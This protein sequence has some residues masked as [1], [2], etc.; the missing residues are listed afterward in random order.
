VGFRPFVYRLAGELDLNGWVLNSSAGL[1]VE[2]EG[3]EAALGQFLTRLDREKPAAAVVLTREVSW[4]APAG[5]TRFEILASDA[6]AEKTAAV[7]PD[8]ATCGD[9][10][11]ELLDPADRRY[12]YPFTNCT[13]C[14]PRYT[15][16][17]DIPYDR[18]RTTMRGFQMCEA[19]RRE[20]GSMTPRYG[21]CFATLGAMPGAPD[22]RT[23]TMGAAGDAIAAASASEIAQ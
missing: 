10:L 7:L 15:I 20:Y 17:L 23:S 19:C 6:G 3:P 21:E 14:G 4:L 1:V 9:C 22:G 12:L 13:N 2:V 18:P 16:I 8:L 5:F 11:G